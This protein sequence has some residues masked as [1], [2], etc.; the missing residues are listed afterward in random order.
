MLVRSRRPA[1]KGPLRWVCASVSQLAS[2]RL[3]LCCPCRYQELQSAHMELQRVMSNVEGPV[4]GKVDTYRA[5][6]KTQEQ[7]RV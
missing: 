4:R 3:Q 5:T 6:I 7:V 1:A 2:G